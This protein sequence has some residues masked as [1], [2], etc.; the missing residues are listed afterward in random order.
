MIEFI[1]NIGGFVI[2]GSALF[3]AAV[4][5]AW[6]AKA[7]QPWWWG[8]I[9]GAIFHGL[10]L[11][12]VVIVFYASRS[13]STRATSHDVDDL[14]GTTGASGTDPFGEPL[15]FA[16]EDDGHN[17]SYERDPSAVVRFVMPAVLVVVALTAL[18]LPFYYLLPAAEN[19]PVFAFGTGLDFWIFF[20]IV[21]I[22]LGAAF[23]HTKRPL[24]A[25]LSFAWVGAW[26]LQLSIAAMLD[27]SAFL[28]AS[29]AVYQLPD[30]YVEGYVENG[31]FVTAYANDVGQAWYLMLVIG[32]GAWS[33][34]LWTSWL[35]RRR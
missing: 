4:G 5:Y 17:V 6:S 20:S 10:G 28:A 33:L 19:F 24:I 25:A 30:L 9:A 27:R 35:R 15:G 14:W 3:W 31:G 2:L 1:T 11:V 13:S 7:G 26:W 23:S 18:T 12:I 16:P 22:G 32:L 21:V 34:S 29:Q 8:A